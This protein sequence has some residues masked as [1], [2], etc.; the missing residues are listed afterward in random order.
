MQP[1]T[2]GRT[3]V[4]SVCPRKQVVSFAGSPC[5][6]P[7]LEMKH[8]DI[9]DTLQPRII[10]LLLPLHRSQSIVVSIRTSTSGARVM[11]TTSLHI[12]DLPRSTRSPP[13]GPRQEGRELIRFWPP[14]FRSK[15]RKIQW[16]Q[17][18]MKLMCR[19]RI[20]QVHRSSPLNDRIT[21]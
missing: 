20:S 12:H 11:S 1:V 21:F 3:Y 2:V 9:L 19:D 17:A 6:A 15:Q 5:W 18:L 14:G 13:G 4:C 16:R 7:A 10:G 8:F